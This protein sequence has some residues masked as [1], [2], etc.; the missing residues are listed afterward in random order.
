MKKLR[1]DDL[2]HFPAMAAAPALALGIY[3]NDIHPL[4]L[5]FLVP[6]FTG[7]FFFLIK[8][9]LNESFRVAV[10]VAASA[11]FF[12]GGTL[13]VISNSGFKTDPLGK[14]R[15]S[16]VN[17]TAKI[18]EIRELNPDRISFTGYVSGISYDTTLRVKKGKIK[19]KQVKTVKATFDPP[20]KLIF[21]MREPPPDL[22]KELSSK[23]EPG[24]QVTLSGSYFKPL[25]RR[26]PGGFDYAGYLKRQKISASIFVYVDSS[27]SVTGEPDLLQGT[28][29][30]VRQSIARKID[31][32]HDPQTAAILKGLIIADRASIDQETLNNYIDTGIAH[33]LAVSG[34]NVGVIYLLSLL[35]FQKLKPIS[36]NGE[37]VARLIIL[38]LF[39]ILT[40][41]Q[42]T[43]VRAVLMFAVH[44]ILKYNGRESNSWNTLSLTAIL[45]L[46]YDPQDLFSTSF[47]LSVA[48]VSGLFI[49][50]KIKTE[51]LRSIYTGLAGMKGRSLTLLDRIARSAIFRNGFELV[52]VTLLV[53]LFML[54]FLIGYFGK[55]TLLSI[56]A[57]IAGVPLSSF[58]LINGMLTLFFST[59]STTL[60]SIIATA[61]TAAN[62]L[63]NLAASSLR[64]TGW[65]TIEITG[66][67]TLEA[68]V[69]YLMILVAAI[70]IAARPS[71]KQRTV[72][73]MAST[74][75]IIFSHFVLNEPLIRDGRAYLI[76]VDVS[77]GDSFLL[78]NST[79]ETWLI[80]AGP[81]SKRFDSGEKIIKPLL[82]QLG[83]DSISLA[84]ISHYDNDHSGGILSLY[85]SGIIKR[86][87]VP[88]PD[89]LSE[90]DIAFF[91]LF[92]RA[93]KPVLLSDG[94]V[95]SSGDMKLTVHLND[96]APGMESNTRS[97]VMMVELIGKKILFTGDLDKKGENSL[98]GK[99][100]N[101]DC[102]LLKVS[103]HGSIT[104]T[105]ESFLKYSL[106]E[107]ALI[108]AGA[109][110]RFRHPH[111][112]VIDRLDDFGINILRTDL[113]GCLIVQMDSNKISQI[114]WR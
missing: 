111:R 82:K 97:A 6:A 85:N 36:R 24:R 83:I 76:A 65:G 2:K 92:N 61:S 68:V 103:H 35:L 52:L 59:F 114:N 14:I 44:S 53:Q 39:L 96:L 81:V 73:F 20:V 37:L 22:F 33:I 46:L 90:N 10:P 32:L 49:A 55:V 13:I 50:E 100:I 60:A 45:T 108:S 69:F 63:I 57:N 3:F 27:I 30:N 8:L 72:I 4:P 78:R 70:L 66:S 41:F 40:Q 74:V 47:Q 75:A 51:L 12:L 17:V 54:P 15:Q 26:N 87:A 102:D 98:M 25:N 11:A 86:L 91:N 43:V 23:L 28:I 109:G 7:S 16:D 110:N 42:I 29:F 99:M 80:D 31:E 89:S 48:A 79:G 104:G 94:I 93:K 88:P 101:L 1:L 106:P 71:L 58:M 21:E 113:E 9:A 67:T 64:S 34:F 19:E 107:I 5:W 18:V 38:F 84:F 95:F 56:P 112:E 105:S 62:Q 77:Q